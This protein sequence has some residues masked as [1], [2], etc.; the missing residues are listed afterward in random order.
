MVKRVRNISPEQREKNRVNARIRAA[1][2]RELM[3]TK[4][5]EWRAQKKLKNPA[6]FLWASAKIRARKQNLPFTITEYDI[7]IPEFCPVLGIPL[8][9]Q[10]KRGFSDFAAS[11]D[12]LIPALG[13]TPD[14]IVVVSW[15]ANRIKH[16]ATITELNQVASFYTKLIG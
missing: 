16:N 7:V 15:R 4:T 3:R 10:T 9:T 1:N 12:K 2:N 6:Y 13:Y 11:I 5:N 14:N 8:D